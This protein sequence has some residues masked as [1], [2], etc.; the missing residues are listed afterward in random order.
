MCRIWVPTP[1]LI[2]S[3]PQTQETGHKERRKKRKKGI[4]KDN[5]PRRPKMVYVENNVGVGV[6][7]VVVVVVTFMKTA[8]LVV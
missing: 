3:V 8:W 6:G 2:D 4:V 5:A 7:V 1:G